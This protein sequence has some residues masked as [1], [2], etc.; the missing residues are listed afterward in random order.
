MEYNIF[1]MA[2]LASRDI[3]TRQVDEIVTAGA[4][5]TIYVRGC[6]VFGAYCSHSPSSCQ[7]N[8]LLQSC[9]YD[10]KTQMMQISIA[11]VEGLSSCLFIHFDMLR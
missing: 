2:C 6:G 11:E 4:M 10:Q 3:G 8:N 1:Q 7:V 5:V 9:D